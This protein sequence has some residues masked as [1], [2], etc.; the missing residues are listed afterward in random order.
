[1]KGRSQGISSKNLTNRPVR[2][3]VGAR[4]VNKNWVSQIGQS[5]GNKATERPEVMRGVRAVPYK[6]AS[7]KPAPLG[8]ELV[9]NVGAGKPGAGR[10]LYGQSGSQQQ[11][12]K[13]NP[14]AN[15]RPS[16]RGGWPDSKR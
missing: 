2:T 3:G 5:M 7:F 12:G 11:Y 15:D 10:T 6:G 8:N 9:N 4:G 1:V 14:G 13:S 16:T